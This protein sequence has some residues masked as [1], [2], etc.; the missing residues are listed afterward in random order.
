MVKKR[1][2]QNDRKVES[3]YEIVMCV[4]W[5]SAMEGPLSNTTV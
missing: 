4:R 5:S 3:F 1:I 2:P